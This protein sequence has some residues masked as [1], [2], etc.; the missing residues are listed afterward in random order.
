M[1]VAPGYF[2][3]L[4]VTASIGRTFGRSEEAP[5]SDGVI[6]LSHGT[7][8]SYFNREERVIGQTLTLANSLTPNPKG[9][10]R[11]YV[12]VGV[13]P[14]GF[15]AA[16]PQVQ[17]WVPAQW[18]LKAGGSMIGRLADHSSM[19]AAEAELGVKLRA[20][21]SG[22]PEIEYQL[23]PALEN[24]VESIRPALLMLSGAAVFVLLI[25]CVNVANLFL[26]RMGERHREIAIRTALGA[27]RG[28]LIRQLVMEGVLLALIAGAAGVAL[29]WVGVGALRS[30]AT[31][32]SR[33]DLGV[34]LAFPRLE[35]VTVDE[36]VLA[37]GGLT[38]L[39]TGLL[40]SLGPAIRH[41]R[42]GQG[43]DALRDSASTPH[44]GFS[45][46]RRGRTRAILVL[47][48][49]AL[50]MVLLVGAALMIHS[51][52]NLSKV[53]PGYD[54]RN[55]LTFQVALPAERYPLDQ[56]K[57]FSENL[58][59]RLNGAPGILGAAY[60]QLPMVVVVES[61][62]FRKH[63]AVPANFDPGGPEIRLVSRDYLDVM[64][65]PVV[66]G[67]GFRDEDG[68][69]SAR[70]LLINERFA[71]TEFAGKDPVGAQAFVG[72]DSSPWEIVGVTRDVR[73]SSL[74]R[75]PG[76][77]VFALVSQWPG[78][79]AFPLG[80]YFSVRTRSEPLGAVSYVRGVVESLDQHAGLFNMAT[81]EHIVANQ[82]SRPRL[83]AALLGTFGALAGALALIGIYGVMSYAV[84]Q[85]TREIGIRMAL[86]A[87]AADV[88][89]LVLRQSLFVAGCGV[90][91]G[92]VGAALLTG[93]LRGMLFGVEPL[94]MMTFV[95][96]TACFAAIA[97]A[98]S[99]IPARRA[100]KVDP[101]SALRWE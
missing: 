27:G 33:I 57:A 74:D 79:N 72:P 38:S 69:G 4:G 44:S 64:A 92:L 91:A 98:A 35:E 17:F 34:Q 39:L 14:E 76:P 26:A 12:V 2:D 22:G 55:V 20:M 31:T 28:R 84:S 50:A 85:R 60:G 52:S 8:R 100:A 41:S 75:P 30:L 53:D 48:E 37:F 5:D 82:M 97:T 90:A 6:I 21:R 3:T 66:S 25:A 93:Y 70:V 61:A 11:Q 7:W 80:P 101:L 71:K 51:F 63:P 73:Q 77:Q 46:F 29:A 96:V 9:D 59:T 13:M 19:A 49:V 86:R 95:L 24:V 36:A 88:L 78:N 83:Y 94:D 1:R 40:F 15:D 54:A 45:L 99:Y 16:N 43:V 62:L 65:I 23:I 10:S 47:A 67:R 58:V 68:E 89:C 56:V 87:K 32:L 81:M 42:A 18:N